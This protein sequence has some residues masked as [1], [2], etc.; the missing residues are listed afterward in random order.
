MFSGDAFLLGFGFYRRI[1]LC[2]G[3]CSW[4]GFA[5]HTPQRI[6]VCIC[7]ALAAHE[8]SGVVAQSKFRGFFPECCVVG[9]AEIAL[10][11]EL[12]V[13]PDLNRNATA[14]FIGRPLLA[15]ML[16]EGFADVDL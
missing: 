7:A 14:V 4:R 15:A 13:F 16:D 5:H 8:R 2:G 3:H 6:A 11:F 10:E 9:V 1:G 12:L